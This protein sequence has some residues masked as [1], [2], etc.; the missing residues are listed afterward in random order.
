MLLNVVLFLINLDIK[1]KRLLVKAASS[2]KSNY[3]SSIYN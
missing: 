1:K 2:F 3:L